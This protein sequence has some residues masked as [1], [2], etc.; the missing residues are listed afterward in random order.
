[1]KAIRYYRYG[2]PEDLKYEEIDIP[3]AGDDQVLVRVHAASVNPLDWHRLRGLPYVVRISDGLTKPKN[4]GLGADLAGR[5]EAFGRHVN[6][7]EEGAEVFGMSI[8]TCAEYVRVSPEGIAPKPANLSFEQAA[9][10]PVAALTALQGLR[11]KGQVQAG[12]KV[13][14][15]GAAGGVGTFAV[16]LAKSFG[17]EVTG[18]CS[19]RNMDLVRSL[20][21]EHVVDY[22]R[23]DFARAGQR[24]DLILEAVGNRTL[25]DCRR[26]L[27]PR[28]T[29]V[30]VGAPE[31]RWI[32]PVLIPLKGLLLSRFVSQRMV[33]FVAKRNKADLL[34]IKELIEAGEVTPVIDRSYPLSEV[35]DAI[36]YLEEGHAR[37]KV[38]I[39][40]PA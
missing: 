30:L 37:G 35:P 32:G 34:L 21:A 28:G 33:F 25:S 24:Y 39:T 12:Q 23:E 16:Q 19:T 17:A 31:G 15:N 26:V 11:D 2:S 4:N 13:L 3:A 9:A 27:G 29:Y 20:G 8:R 1:M 18:V 6:G 40:M 7:F 14:I 36:R 5:V 22:T 10:V 38:V